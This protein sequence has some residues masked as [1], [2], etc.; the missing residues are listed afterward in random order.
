MRI[1]T[2]KLKNFRCFKEQTFRFSPQFNLLI[3]DNGAGKTT[4][5]DALAVAIGSW[6]LGTGEHSSRPIYR[7]EV[8]LTAHEHG[9]NISFEEQFPVEVEAWGEVL[10]RHIHWARKLPTAKSRT[11][12]GEANTIKGLSQE[13]TKRARENGGVVL[14]IL[15]YYGTG[16]LW[17]QPRNWKK[18]R[19]LKQK[20]LSRLIAY[21]DA[22]DPRTNAKDLLDW[23]RRQSWVSFQEGGD[24]EALRSVKE[25]IVEAIEGAEEI[26][27]DAKRGEIVV[28]FH[29]GGTQ[30]FSNLSDGQR[31]MVALIGDIAIRIATLNPQIA[32]RAIKETEG[33][34]LID[35]LDL[36]LHPKWQRSI[37]KRLRETFPKCQFI[38]TTHSPQI[39]GEVPPEEIRLLSRTQ[40]ESPAQSLGMDSNWVLRVLMNA[41]EQNV[42]VK[43]EIAEVFKM[44]ERRDLETAMAK[45]AELRAKLGNSEALQRAASTV[46]RIRLLGQ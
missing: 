42:D 23:I 16:R 26:G 40:I 31:N 13:A 20:N 45:I 27:F 14:P 25:A 44:I 19:E 3:G 22:I 33:V 24:T 7:Q 11:T 38:C 30:P 35:E 10:N 46:E 15:A 41:E 1:E 36:H 12:H 21:R 2:L 6:L 29:E 9:T 17:Q 28:K 4:V 43:N 39:V 8:R 18:V 37:V 34:I 5:L 32:E